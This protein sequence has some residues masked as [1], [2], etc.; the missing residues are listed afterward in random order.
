MSHFF[1]GN[2]FKL[3]FGCATANF[4]TLFRGQ[5]HSPDVNHCVIQFQ[6]EGVRELRNE[7]G[8]LSP[9]KHLVGFEQGIFRF[10]YNTL[11]HEAT[12]LKEHF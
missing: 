4:G 1:R 8:S 2:I 6:P 11:T 9:A 7:V 3:F 10:Y 12:L 5:P